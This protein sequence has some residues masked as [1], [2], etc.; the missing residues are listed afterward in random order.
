[1][2]EFFVSNHKKFCYL[3]WIVYV[4]LVIIILLSF[5][6]PSIA[7]LSNAFGKLAV[8]TYILTLIPGV[9]K[10][11]GL[12][13]YIVSIILL[14]RRQIGIL[15]FLLALT[16]MILSG[17]FLSSQPFVIVGTIA[18][19]ILF[20]LFITSNNFC[21][22]VLSKNWHTLQQLTYV[23]MFFIFLH[24]ILVRFS[25]SGLLL[26]IVMIAELFSFT[27]VLHSNK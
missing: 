14:Y 26:L 22:K 9:A 21:V 25:W 20:L 19:F 13:F 27:K 2:L 11:F 23:A 8:L 7:R 4:L 5:G 17:M 16:H 3:F 24:L 1:M 10:R 18:M 12:N 15:M 6:N